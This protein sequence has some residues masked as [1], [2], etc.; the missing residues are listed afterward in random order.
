MCVCL[1]V[2]ITQ[3]KLPQAYSRAPD[4]LHYNAHVAMHTAYTA[5]IVDKCV[6]IWSC[7]CLI[8]DND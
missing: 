5:H 8:N 3:T 7:V 4:V 1:S 6:H 2:G